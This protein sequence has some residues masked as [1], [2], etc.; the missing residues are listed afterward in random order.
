MAIN[1]KY[2]QLLQEFPPRPVVSQEDFYATQ[3]VINKLLVVECGNKVGV[4]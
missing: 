1:K 2:I 3:T 4:R